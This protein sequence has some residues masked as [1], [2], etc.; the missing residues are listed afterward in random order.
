[1]ALNEAMM[2]PSS[3][4]STKNVLAHLSQ[5]LFIVNL[6]CAKLS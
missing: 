2:S 5:I 1:M 6:I 4:I 3:L